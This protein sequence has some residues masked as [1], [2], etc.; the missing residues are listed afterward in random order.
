LRYKSGLKLSNNDKNPIQL[1]GDMLNML[2]V[3]I[4]DFE[5]RVKLTSEMT[6]QTF[7]IK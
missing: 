2:L 4:N 5:E 1:F 7:K 3:K 6:G